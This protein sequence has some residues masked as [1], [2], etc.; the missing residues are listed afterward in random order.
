[1]NK[2]RLIAII[3]YFVPFSMECQITSIPSNQK[4]CD[5]VYDAI[6]DKIYITIPS[7]DVING[8]SIGVV[9]PYTNTLESTLLVGNDPVEM[10][11]SDNGQYIY[12]GFDGIPK[13]RRYTLNPL[14]F[15]MEFDLGSYPPPLG[16][17]SYYARDIAVMPGQPNTIAVSRKYIANISPDYI[18]IGIY[19]NGVMRPTDYRP[20]GGGSVSKIKFKDA[21][22]LIGHRGT[23]S[24]G[25]IQLFTINAN[26]IS[27]SSS[28]DNIPNP[29][30]YGITSDFV[31]RQNKL[32]FMNGRRVDVSSTPIL[33]GQYTSSLFGGGGVMYDELNNLVCYGDDT[34]VL[35]FYQNGFWDGYLRRYNA[36]TMQLFDSYQI[37]TAN[38]IDKMISCGNNCYSLITNTP[39]GAA[40]GGGGVNRVVI[41]RAQALNT[42]ESTHENN[43]L[44]YPNPTS[45]FVHVEKPEDVGI[46]NI[47]IR[48]LLGEVV[49]TNLNIDTFDLSSISSGIYFCHITTSNGFVFTKKITKE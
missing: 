40:S 45:G 7:S 3:F 33:D 23:S 34:G 25:G 2:L 44:L 22:T 19:D 41:L 49:L 36:I 47:I 12:V 21:T 27:L 43:I 18:G 10:A 28:H 37:T 4:A 29:H 46:R 32:Y 15:D 20:T 16:Y 14:A 6:T 31:Y 42:G 9:N 30:P 1:M 8:N 17:G 35:T 26:G 5:L 24:L 11:I 13:I 39:V 38:K 48:N